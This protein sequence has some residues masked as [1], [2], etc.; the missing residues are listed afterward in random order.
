[1]SRTVTMIREP[2][3]GLVEFRPRPRLDKLARHLELVSRCRD[4]DHEIRAVFDWD[5]FDTGARMLAEI[6]NRWEIR[7]V[8]EIT[9]S[10]TVLR[11]TGL[12]SAWTERM[13]RRLS[14]RLERL[15]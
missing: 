11:L 5:A 14:A 8:T 9:G 1:M 13:F 10:G 15:R 6:R 7:P 2:R 12:R 3:S 4:A